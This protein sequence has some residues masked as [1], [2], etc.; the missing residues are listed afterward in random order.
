M[1]SGRVN[2]MNRL[3][4]T[5][6][7]RK[8]ANN[9]RISRLMG[10]LLVDKL[11][12]SVEVGTYL[13]RDQ[14]LA[15]SKRLRDQEQE[16]KLF[17]LALANEKEVE[18]SL[19]DPESKKRIKIPVRG[20][21]CEHAQAFDLDTWLESQLPSTFDSDLDNPCLICAEWLKRSDLRFC[22]TTEAKLKESDIECVKESSV[23]HVLILPLLLVCPT[24]TL[25][26][27]KRSLPRM[28]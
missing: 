1:Q 23:L 5:S 3:T 9:V 12:L 21:Q 16:A 26:Q 13:S 11:S 17:T 24:S 7:L 15:Q 28:L 18:I 20:Q 27:R 19:E 10:V 22:E 2:E 25:L 4:I 8:D 14:L 6:S